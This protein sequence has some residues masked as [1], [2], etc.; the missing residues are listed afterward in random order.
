MTA[1]KDWEKR[2]RSLV[3]QQ[4]QDEARY[5]DTEALL[6][7]IIIRLTLAA[8]GYHPLLDPHLKAL[9][10]TL[11]NGVSPAL[12]PR[13]DELSDTLMRISDDTNAVSVA[14]DF[15][16]RLIDAAALPDAQSRAVRQWSQ[17]LSSQ[18]VEALTDAQLKEFLS[19][20][21][22]QHPP[23]P[24]KRGFLNRVF[25]G[26]PGEDEGEAPNL[27]LAKLLQTIEWPPHWR[28]EIEA[29]QKRLTAADA[30]PDAWQT[31]ISGLVKMVA[32]AMG[33]L[34]TELRET[35][36]FLATLTEHLNELDESLQGG[37]Q[38]RVDA[39]EMGQAM[40]DQVNAEVGGL[41]ASVS[42]AK[43]LVQLKQSVSRRLVAI[44]N[45]VDQHQAEYERR[46]QEDAAREKALRQ[47]LDT[48][49]RETHELRSRMMQ[50]RHQALL[51]AVTGLPNRMA[52]DERLAQE[53]SRWR[54]FGEPL[55]LMVWDMDDFK[56]VND[57]F[58]HQAGDKALRVVAGTFQQR[59]RETDFIARY[60]G[61]EFA[62]L[63][64]GTDERNAMKVADDLRQRVE[65]A[66]FH[67]GAKP[68]RLTLSCGISEFR[69][70]D[71]P[72]DVFARADKALYKAKADGKNRCVVGD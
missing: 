35:E 15:I 44:K 6:S 7:R 59:L 68:V 30:R 34:E 19:L 22:P 28:I 27:A 60:G 63:L 72:E 46:I 18:P 41:A 8:E 48:V 65:N 24:Q 50:A 64:V 16:D 47:R 33:S 61:E 9:R 55:S 40:S 39:L 23:A 66:G 70:G 1:A 42:S 10:D 17:D 13:L 32:D 20:L 4:R 12:K 53:Y 52:W 51:D 31:V 5:A 26:P 71:T 38:R 43:D 62:M 25:G 36:G 14:G 49:E 57:R 54:R 2:F 37:E 45:A 67:S 69:G 11:R 3:D 21:S 56:Q 58:G 29:H